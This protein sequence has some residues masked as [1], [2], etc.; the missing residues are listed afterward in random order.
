MSFE[1]L[2]FWWSFFVACKVRDS[3]VEGG[4]RVCDTVGVARKQGSKSI[5]CINVI[6]L[7]DDIH[8]YSF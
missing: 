1:G 2:P 4:L 8:D 3:L 6:Q 7:I 5:N